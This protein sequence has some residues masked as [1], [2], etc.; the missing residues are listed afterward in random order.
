MS[1][2]TLSALL[3]LAISQIPAALAQDQDSAAELAAEVAALRQQVSALAERL[4]AL[5]NSRQASPPRP[6]AARNNR[7]D[8]RKGW[9]DNMRLE[10]KKAE[11][12]ASGAWTDPKTWESIENGMKKKEVVALL[13]E[14]TGLK[15]S[16]RKDTD[17]IL[18]YR[19]DLEG[20]GEPVEGE[21]RIYKGKVRRFIVPD[22]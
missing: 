21:I 6:S 17:E 10:L 8:E 15:F 7:S 18:Y 14:P 16:V 13:G 19:G 11:V 3:L 20:N 12:R 22:F 5:E 4:D 9:F 1:R 2:P